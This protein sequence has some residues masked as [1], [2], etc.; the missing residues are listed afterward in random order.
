MKILSLKNERYELELS[1]G[2][3][4]QISQQLIEMMS[5]ATS[6]KHSEEE[7][8]GLMSSVSLTH[9]LTHSLTLSLSLP[10]PRSLTLCLSVSLSSSKE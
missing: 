6:N 4:G 5:Q 8:A 2:P 9:T 7:F 10:L 3:G 1:G